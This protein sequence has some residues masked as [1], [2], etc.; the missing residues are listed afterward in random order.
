[1][2]SSGGSGWGG[3]Y[4]NFVVASANKLTYFLCFFVLGISS[5]Y[6]MWELPDLSCNVWKIVAF[7]C[8]NHVCIG[9]I[10]HLS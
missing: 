1:M 7:N 4:K 3:F 6:C 9:G 5:S 8:I 2:Y 10:L